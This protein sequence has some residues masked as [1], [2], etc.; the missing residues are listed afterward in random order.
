LLIIR[1]DPQ[2][3]KNKKEN[4]SKDTD[5]FFTVPRGWEWQ[6]QQQ[7]NAESLHIMLEVMSS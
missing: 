4:T 6:T 7:A 3:I 5:K 1:R 2:A